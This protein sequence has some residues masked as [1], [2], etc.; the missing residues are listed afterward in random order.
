[1][2]ALSATAG[3]ILGMILFLLNEYLNTFFKRCGDPFNYTLNVEDMPAIKKCEG[4]CVKLVQKIGTPMYSVRRTC[5]DD[6][7]MYCVY[8]LSLTLYL[9]LIINLVNWKC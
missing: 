6:L 9:Y 8:Y 7:G 5:T 4:C 3:M 1:M 2:I